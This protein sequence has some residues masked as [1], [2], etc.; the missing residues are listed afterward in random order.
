MYFAFGKPFASPQALLQVM[1]G[2]PWLT[3]KTRAASFR[4]A[5]PI[6]RVVY[7]NF[8]KA[9]VHPFWVLP[10]I[11]LLQAAS[12]EALET[13]PLTAWWTVGGTVPTAVPTA[14][15]TAEAVLAALVV[16]FTSPIVATVAATAVASAALG[17]FMAPLSIA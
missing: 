16:S 13:A 17:T 4:T 15:S 10:A 3:S 5:I 8:A 1:P 7:M 14:V 12:P 2:P 6:E 11:D 9:R